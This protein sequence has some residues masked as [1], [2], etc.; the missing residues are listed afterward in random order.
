MPFIRWLCLARMTVEPGASVEIRHLRCFLAIAEDRNVTR[1]AARLHL[2]QPALS[3]TLAQLEQRLGA[4]LVTR[5]THHL[6]LTDAGRAFEASAREAVRVFDAAVASTAAGVAPLRFGH[7]W[8]TATHTAAIVRAWRSAFTDRPLQVQRSE[9]RLAGLATGEVDVALVHGPVRDR[10]LRTALID[11]EPR[12]AALPAAHRLASAASVTLDQLACHPLII[13]TLSGTTTL[14]LWPTGPKPPIAA[15]VLTVEDWLIAIASGAGFGI[16]A[17]STAAQHPWPDL[18]YVPVHDV[19]S[20]PLLLAWPAR[21]AHPHVKSF[22]SL[23]KRATQAVSGTL[24][25]DRG[26]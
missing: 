12:V 13:N 24:R 4:Q 6:D 2:S 17:A 16:S 21:G 19:A 20:I 25:A 23:A 5:S 8:S 26:D 14:D 10:S 11:D 9:E 18:R 1:A 7:A 22:V 3:R 15:D